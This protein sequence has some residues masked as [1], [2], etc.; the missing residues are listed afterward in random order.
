MEC[1]LLC[2]ISIFQQI[3]IALHFHG[4]AS[5]H[6]SH[7]VYTGSVDKH[8]SLLFK[9]DVVGGVL[10]SSGDAVLSVNSSSSLEWSDSGASVSTEPLQ[11]TQGTWY[12]VLASRSVS[13]LVICSAWWNI[14]SSL[15]QEWCEHDSRLQWRGFSKHL[16]ST[17]SRIRC[18]VQCISDSRGWSEHHLSL[19]NHLLSRVL[20]GGW[21]IGSDCTGCV[22][23][24]LITVDNNTLLL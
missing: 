1:N 16:S 7:S 22:S 15:Q 11:L 6:F 9:P 13:V 24:A 8:I 2:N 17:A 23:C 5:T 20:R 4:N 10:L 21:G 19:S 14:T 3:D 18:I 12:H